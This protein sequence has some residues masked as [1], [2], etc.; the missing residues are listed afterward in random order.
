EQALSDL[1]VN[2]PDRQAVTDA[3]N[4]IDRDLERNP[5]STGESRD[6]DTRIHIVP[7]LPFCSMSMPPRGPSRS[8]PCG[9]YRGPSEADHD[10]S[11]LP[12]RPPPPPA[13][14]PAGPRS[15]QRDAP[16]AGAVHLAAVR[17]PR[18]RRAQR[19]RLDAG[20]LPAVGGHAR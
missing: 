10:P 12:G 3:A 1:W 7:P 2:A 8:G 13:S 9:G 14:S 5:L 16:L 20:Q 19:D 4:Q 15:G 17:P 6:G 18:P 11:P